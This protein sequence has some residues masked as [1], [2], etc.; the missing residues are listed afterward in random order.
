MRTCVLLLAALAVTATTAY[1]QMGRMDLLTALD[2]GHVRALF[3]GNGE[4]S[5]RGVIERDAWGPEQLTIEPGTQFIA[6]IGPGGGGIGGRGGRGGGGTQGMGMFGR[7][8]IDLRD[9]WVAE[10][11]LPTVCTAFGLRAPGPQDVMVPGPSPDA[12]MVQLLSLPTVSAAPHGAFQIAAWAIANDPLAPAVETVAAAWVKQASTEALTPEA[13][14][15]G[16]ADLLSQARGLLRLAGC[17]AAQFQMFA[18][19]AP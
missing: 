8:D 10:V 18:P 6:Q 17:D 7:A 9:R 16:V 14:A 13:T 1:G 5:I 2:T 4:S 12:R 3:T 19:A 15:T 11:D